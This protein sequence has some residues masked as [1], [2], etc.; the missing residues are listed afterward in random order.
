MQTTKFIP[1]MQPNLNE[2]DIQQVVRVLR[3]G[4]LI[5]GNEVLGLEQSVSKYLSVPHVSAVSNGTATLHIALKSL[6]IGVGDEVIVPAFSYIATANVVELVGAKP[7]F[8]DIDDHTF[9]ID[10][11]QIEAAITDK[12]KCIIPVHEFGLP[13]NMNRVMELAR[14]YNLFVI[15]DAACAL[16]ATVGD[17]FV[18]TFGD[19][20]SFSLHPRKAITSGEGGLITTSSAALDRKA[21]ILRN[22]G[23]DPAVPYMDFVDAGF[24]YRLTDFQA[25]LVHSQLGRLEDGIAFRNKIAKIY[26]ERLSQ[27]E[28]LLPTT[29]DGLKHTWQTFHIVFDPSINRNEVIIKMKENGVGTNYGAQCMPYQTFFKNKYELDSNRLFPNAMRAYNQGLALPCYDR[30]SEDDAHQVVDVLNSII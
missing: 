23:M 5:Q 16:G 6:G 15:E 29:P 11:D 2:D 22:H 28:I 9:T 7:I 25:A 8:V 30:M 17:Q 1:L 24:N 10:V 21:R 12:T 20:G 27:S 26:L 19:Y 13:A 3:S 4:M 14:R 18:G